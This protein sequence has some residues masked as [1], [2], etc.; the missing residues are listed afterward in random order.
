M[1]NSQHRVVLNEAGIYCRAWCFHHA[2]SGVSGF[3]SASCIVALG[4]NTKRGAK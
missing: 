4:E 3:G 2:H 1:K